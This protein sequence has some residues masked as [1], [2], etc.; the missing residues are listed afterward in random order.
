[1]LAWK[2]VWLLPHL[3]CTTIG[4]ASTGL[5]EATFLTKW[6]RGVGY[7]GTPWSGHTVKWYWLTIFSSLEPSFW[8]EK[9]R[10]VYSA[11][12]STS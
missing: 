8:R 12:V 11:S 1:M 6:R 3:Q 9:V 7:S 2:S 4:P 10:I 5:A